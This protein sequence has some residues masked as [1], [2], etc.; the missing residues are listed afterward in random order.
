MV[1]FNLDLDGIDK[2]EQQRKKTG[3]VQLEASDKANEQFQGKEVHVI[4]AGEDKRIIAGWQST[5][6]IELLETGT[7]HVPHFPRTIFLPASS[8]G[9]AAVGMARPNSPENPGNTGNQEEYTLLGLG[10][11]TV[12]WIQVYVVG[13]YVRTKD[14][15][16][17]QEKLIRTVNPTAS[18]LIPSEKDGLRNKLLDPEQSREMWTELLKTPG[19]K[20]AWRI[21]PTRNT[22]FGH[23]R[24]GFVNGINKGKA[25]QRKL[26]PPGA[27]ESEFDS[28]EFGEAVQQL[29]SIFT[30]GKAPKQS[31]LI[32]A[33]DA[34]GKLDV[35]Y[36]ANP[37]G[38]KKAVMERMGAVSDERVARLIWLGYLTGGKVSSPAAREGVAQGCVEWA[39]RPVGSIETRVI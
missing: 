17:M 2:A 28:E 9:E 6:E 22:D 15:S 12:M 8:E 29:R 4:G 20:T 5:E 21:S 31:V 30:G 7:S 18:T 37:E 26:M 25:E 27:V 10:I 16:E 24:D 36:Q 33:R 34:V 35:L 39:S 13:M 32:L 19:I 3:G 38:G 11:R 14:I 1:L 23:L